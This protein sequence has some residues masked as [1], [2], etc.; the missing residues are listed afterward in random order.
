VTS[1]IL[2]TVYLAGRIAYALG[3]Y[4]VGFYHYYTPPSALKPPPPATPL[5]GFG[6]H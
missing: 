3:Y 5:L 4:Q 2:G 6:S 1:A